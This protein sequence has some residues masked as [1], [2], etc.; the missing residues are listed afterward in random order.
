VPNPWPVQS[1]DALTYRERLLALLICEEG[2]SDR[3]IGERMS[4]TVGTVKVY[5]SRIYVKLGFPPRGE[6]GAHG[7][8][9]LML[10]Y[11]KQRIA[12]YEAIGPT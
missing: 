5:A 11:W 2:I 9:A 10:W 12:E 8:C 1:V 7:R 6:K 4:I 3:E